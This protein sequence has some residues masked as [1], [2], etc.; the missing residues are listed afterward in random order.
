MPAAGMTYDI[1]N[2]STNQHTNI[3]CSHSFAATA[4]AVVVYSVGLPY[5]PL[6]MIIAHLYILFLANFFPDLTW[7]SPG[8]K[9]D[10][11]RLHMCVTRPLATPLTVLFVR[12]V[13]FSPL[14]GRCNSCSHQAGALLVLIFQWLPPSPAGCSTQSNL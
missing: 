7:N 10:S 9:I 12:Q 11:Y 13:H 4:A 3:T 8:W 14:L 6:L 1:I 5:H 2:K